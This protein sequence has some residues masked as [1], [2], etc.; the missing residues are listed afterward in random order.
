MQFMRREI[1]Q[2]AVKKNIAYSLGFVH[3]K[4][5]VKI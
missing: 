1:Q 4:I 3:K 2:E 5:I